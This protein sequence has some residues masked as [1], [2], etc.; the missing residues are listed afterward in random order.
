MSAVVRPRGHWE[1]I[2]LGF[3]LVRPYYGRM[4][5]TSLML[6]APLFVALHLIFWNAL[7]WAPVVLWW[8]KPL[9]ERVHLHALARRLFGDAPT[10][11]ETL[12]AFASYGFL[13]WLPALTLRRLSPT[14]S[15]DL[16]ISQL[17][18]LSGPERRRRI[19]LLHRDGTS[20]GAGWLTLV[21]ANV[22]GFLYLALALAIEFSIPD[23][24]EFGVLD[25][26]GL[27]EEQLPLTQVMLAAVVHGIALLVA[28][29][30]VGGG[31]GLYINRRTILEGWDLEIAFRRI[32]TRVRALEPERGRA[33]TSA[34]GAAVLA[35]ALLLG[36]S[37]SR[38]EG[39]AEDLSPAAAGQAITRVLTSD[40]FHQIQITRVPR[41]LLDWEFDEAEEPEESSLPEWIDDFFQAMGTFIGWIAAMGRGILIA[42]V[43]ALVGY[44]VY[45]ARDE[46]KWVRGRGRPGRA[47]L[48]SALLS[49]DLRRQSLPDDVPGC[50][51]DLWR[52]GEARE[53]LAL[54]YRATL[55]EFAHSHDVVFGVG[56]TERECLAA[57]SRGESRERAE[58][59]RALTHSWQQLAYAHRSIA[60]S[61][62][63]SLCND[64]AM[65]FEH[66]SPEPTEEP[67]RG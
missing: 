22:E 44:A 1:A 57:V 37:T 58:F 9:W 24:V 30:Y 41:L 62:V 27:D 20:T 6:T 56:F 42:L 13:Q 66:R 36:S 60:T 19:A 2:D 40:V 15:M 28:P 61:A 11:R 47:A 59:F 39:S 32:A 65:L 38:A 3:R 48:P 4:L 29:F 49:F 46:L 25:W 17:E 43:L 33:A 26:F 63:E 34:T 23:H 12:R 64:W 45:R 10:P 54:L 50:A 35:L 5:W 7:G 67:S 16:A 21:C 52:R 55:S 14:R 53:A 51:L 8:L 31:F 18:G